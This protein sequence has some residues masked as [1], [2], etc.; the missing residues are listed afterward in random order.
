ME[1]KDWV[2]LLIGISFTIIWPIILYFLKP[3]L[4]IRNL[5]F[6]NFNGDCLSFT[7][8]NIGCSNAVNLH[9]EIC[10]VDE[11]F[12]YYLKVDKDDFIILPKRKHGS[13]SHERV[14]KSYDLAKNT[15][16][17]FQG[18]FNDFLHFLRN[19]DGLLVRV[20]IHANHCYSGF[21]KAFEQCFVYHNGF[22][23]IT[24]EHY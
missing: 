19:H 21:G 7:V 13:T 14:F 5:A 23:Q 16:R 17:H 22:E 18:T 3:I 8:E 1:T 9:I 12:T 10:V 2:I 20:R 24:C 11:D 15:R 4:S 6:L